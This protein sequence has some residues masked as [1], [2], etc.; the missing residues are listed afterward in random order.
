MT[1]EL[2]APAGSPEALDAAAGEGADAVY[3]GLKS[4]NA[5]MRSSNF[6][7]ARFEAALR[8]LRRMGKKAYVTVNTVF[9]QRESDRMYQLLRYLSRVGPDA[10]IV[11]DF[12]VVAMARSQFPDLK[13]HASTQMNVASAAG[14][15]ALSRHGV[16]RAVLARELSLEELK[17]ARAGTNVEL[18]VFVHG[19]LCVSVSGLCLFTSYLGG[20]SANRGMCA[21]AC[22]RLY[23]SGDTD[24]GY[25]FSPADLQ[26]LD[27][28]PDLAEAGINAI[29]IEGRMK[30]AEYVGAVV[31]AYRLV[32]DAALENPGDPGGEKVSRAMEKGRKI[33]LGDFAR[34]K[35]RFYFDAP[36]MSRPEHSCG[37]C[38]TC[39]TRDC[40]SCGS[41]WLS[42][43]Q[44]GGTGIALG[45]LLKARGPEG[46]RLGFVSAAAWND[47]ALADAPPSPGDSARLHKKDDSARAPCKLAVVEAARETVAGAKAS[48]YWISIPDGFEAGDRAYLIQR[49]GAARRYKPITSDESRGGRPP[50][51]EKA[52]EPRVEFKESSASAQAGRKPG[53]ARA[54]AARDAREAF[55]EGLYVALSRIEDMYI[56]QSA[57]P[58]KIML[59]LTRRNARRLIEGEGAL[60]FRPE[61]V[62]ISLDPFFPQ[63]DAR[64]VEEETRELF[65]LGYRR[66]VANNMGHFPILKALGPEAR[67]ISGPWLYGLNAWALSFLAANGAWG[68]VSPFE[69]NRQNL[70]RSCQQGAALRERVFVPIFAHPTLYRIRADLSARYDFKTFADGRDEGFLLVGGEGEGSKVYP[71]RPFSIIDKVEFLKEAGFRRFLIDLSGLPL[72]K[73]EYRDLMRA[74]ERGEALPGASRFNWKDGFFNDEAPRGISA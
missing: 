7:Y 9:E 57:R 68:F 61:D 58:A 50:G 17:D 52:P 18:E 41:S 33:L 73:R 59:E 62:I 39:D 27:R 24:G 65:D 8:A 25:Y 48:G 13:L 34:G 3:L 46:N 45:E 31:S 20:K 14:C 55:P 63:A 64:A 35:S 66:F 37:D 67:V 54:A 10:L 23:K 4:F 21:Q 12:G 60:P 32:L 29:K 72:K 42:P 6:T 1:V 30:S 40:A 28:L 74:V 44:D 26:L 71:Q 53:G 43:D 69:N 70:D 38:A 51:H 16:S 36:K 2:L 22:R 11:Q 47:A 56:V 19:A 5:R 49:R 15:N